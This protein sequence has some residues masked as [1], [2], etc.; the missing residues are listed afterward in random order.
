MAA[1]FKIGSLLLKTLSK[2]LANSLKRRAHQSPAF[3]RFCIDLA[4]GYNRVDSRLKQNWLDYKSEPIVPLSAPRAVELGANF[5]SELLIFGVGALTILLETLRSTSS[6][7][8][9]KVKGEER[10]QQHEE[11]IKNLKAN[12]ERL[13]LTLNALQAS[14]NDLKKNKEQIETTAVYIEK[15]A[16]L[17]PKH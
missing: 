13:E 11:E 12:A 9:V 15:E 1:T 14:F 8:K 2:P 5:L 10:L 6:T 4:Q 7:K 3:E 16:T 17:I